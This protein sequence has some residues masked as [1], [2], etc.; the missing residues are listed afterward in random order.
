VD[1]FVHDEILISG[2]FKDVLSLSSFPSQSV[3]QIK[4][5]G[6]LR[7]WAASLNQARLDLSTRGGAPDDEWVIECDI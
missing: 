5:W 2:R 1:L 6:D 4:G 3:I 7:R